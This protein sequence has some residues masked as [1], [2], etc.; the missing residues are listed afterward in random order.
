MPYLDGANVCVLSGVLVLV[1]TVL[2][3]FALAEVDTELDKEDHD[4]LERGDGAVAGALR[5]DMFVEQL[6]SSLLLV[7]SDEFLG[8]FT[9]LC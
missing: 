8:T 3:Q 2:G 7:D 6:E 1:E 5:G 9:A 4:G